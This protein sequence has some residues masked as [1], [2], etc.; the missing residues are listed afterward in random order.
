MHMVIGAA[1]CYW[2]M[3]M[4]LDNARNK[5]MDARTYVLGNQSVSAFNGES[6]M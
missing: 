5:G 2:E 6:N 4:I 3:P 1:D